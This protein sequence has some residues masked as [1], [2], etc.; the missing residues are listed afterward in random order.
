M[1][2]PMR[3]LKQVSE[4]MV[5]STFIPGGA[6]QAASAQ[7]GVGAQVG[8]A[9][10][11]QAGGCIAPPIFAAIAAGTT[12]VALW[13][14]VLRDLGVE[15][16]RS[17]AV[18]GSRHPRTLFSPQHRR[19]ALTGDVHRCRPRFHL[20]EEAL[21]T[22]PRLL[23]PTRTAERVSPTHA[24]NSALR[25]AAGALLVLACS[26]ASASAQTSRTGRDIAAV[27]AASPLGDATSAIGLSS[28]SS[29]VAVDAPRDPAHGVRLGVGVTIGI[30]SASSAAVGVTAG[31]HRKIYTD[32][33]V[34]AD[35]VVEET[36]DGVRLLTVIDSAAAPSEYRYPV[37]LK[38]GAALRL[39]RDGSVDI[40]SVGGEI[41]ASVGVPWATD[42][43]HRPVPTRYR[44]AGR[45]IVQQVDLAGAEFPVVAD[46][47]VSFSCHIPYINCHLDLSRDAT[48]AI[49][50]LICGASSPGSAITLGRYCT[51]AGGLTAGAACAIAA[52][53]YGNQLKAA[54]AWG[55]AHNGCID[56]HYQPLPVWPP[57][58][59]V[60]YITH[61]NG[62]GCH[63]T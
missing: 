53:I 5:C 39:R 32:T 23:A 34:G 36:P 41:I 33:A 57:R 55:K 21:M 1:E 29:S 16:Q 6:A 49:C 42:A 62:S 4:C 54:A 45:T 63:N 2:D 19:E 3:R 15:R 27:V 47:S 13:A 28:T 18:T 50:R 10:A 40:V 59:V 46:P 26:T 7:A 12:S 8:V 48:R 56:I 52:V 44:V 11:T 51:A 58:V 43:T 35:T 24:C 25:I 14:N 38:A 61:D 30:P 31:A 17:A 22:H 9:P 60:L 37:E 20:R